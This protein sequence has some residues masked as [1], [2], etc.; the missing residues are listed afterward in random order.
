MFRATGQSVE[1]MSGRALLYEGG[2]QGVGIAMIRELIAR[3]RFARTLATRFIPPSVR[4]GIATALLPPPDIELFREALSETAPMSAVPGRVVMVCGSLQPGGAERQVANTLLGVAASPIE[5][6]T[7]LCDFLD[8]TPTVKHNFYLPLAQTSGALIRAIGGGGD[9]EREKLPQG[10]LN[11]ASRL[12]PSLVDDVTNLYHE[13]RALRPAVV[14]AWLDWSNVRAGLA[15]VLAGVPKVVLSGRNLSPRHFAL[16]TDYFHP[17]YLALLEREPGNVLLLNNSQAGANDYADWLSME[18]GKVEV[19]RNGV[20]F[21]ENMRPSTEHIGTFRAGLDIP[22]DAPLVGGMFRFNL[23]KQPLLWLEA[24]AKIA[25]V[26][27]DAYF[28]IF[29]RGAMRPQMENAIIALGIEKRT[30]LCDVITPSLNG[31]SPCD[32]VLLTSSG[33][34]TPNVLLEAQ[35]LGLPVVTTNAGGAAEAVLNGI[36]GI[37]ATQDDASVIANAV[38]AILQDKNFCAMAQKEGPSFIAG[39]YGMGRMIEETLAA[40]RLDETAYHRETALTPIAEA[41]AL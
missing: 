30:R 34:G 14:H 15:A 27:P 23:E 36:T 9:A 21:P 32:L 22:A 25:E 41:K 18:P 13:F 38:T 8:E 7:L 20:H 37:V 16:N 1:Q 6:V 2:I 31:L 26:M 40:Y 39:R 5:S 24:A 33:E 4:Q 28:V 3:N 12:H 11:M 29:G 35:W 17:I 19:I 10:F